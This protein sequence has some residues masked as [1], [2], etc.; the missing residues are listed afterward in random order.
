MKVWLFGYPATT[1]FRVP[2]VLKIP[3]KFSLKNQMKRWSKKAKNLNTFLGTSKIV[4]K[5]FKT[6]WV[7]RVSRNLGWTQAAILCSKLQSIGQSNKIM[8]Q[9]N[10]ISQMFETMK[11][12]HNYEPE[13]FIMVDVLLGVLWWYTFNYLKL[14]KVNRT[15]SN[16]YKLFLRK[17]K[18][19]TLRRINKRNWFSTT[20]ICDSLVTYKASHYLPPRLKPLQ[21]GKTCIVSTFKGID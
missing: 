4:T 11:T 9:Q 15:A 6:K 16:M 13:K 10:K 2:I 19:T 3:S 18:F 7:L 1:Y 21:Y 5:K 17:C 12:Y 14:R 20:D 8:W